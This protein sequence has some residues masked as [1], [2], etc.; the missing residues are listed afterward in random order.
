MS[1][2][3]TSEG[4]RKRFGKEKLLR[5]VIIMHNRHLS[6][7][8]LSPMSHFHRLTAFAQSGKTEWPQGS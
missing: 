6:P 1:V 2:E 8:S 7:F 3:R 4:N 5:L